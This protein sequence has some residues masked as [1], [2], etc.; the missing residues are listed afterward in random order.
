MRWERAV[1]YTR[2]YE[3]TILNTP[4]RRLRRVNRVQHCDK[5]PY[6]GKATAPYIAKNLIKRE[7]ARVAHQK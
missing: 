2:A 3:T 5:T 1:L 7:N 4:T 6:I